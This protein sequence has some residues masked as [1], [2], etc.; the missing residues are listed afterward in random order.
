M[1]FTLRV[2]SSWWTMRS[3]FA[4]MWGLAGIGHAAPLARYNLGGKAPAVVADTVV[5]VYGLGGRSVGFDSL[6]T[7]SRLSAAWKLNALGHWVKVLAGEPRTGHHVWKG[8]K[9]V[10]AGISICSEVRTNLVRYS[11]ALNVSAHWQHYLGISVEPAGELSGIPAFRL[12]DANTDGFS[13]INQT[14]VTHADGVHVFKMLVAKDQN[15]TSR[16]SMRLVYSV[17][18]VGIFSGM[19]VDVAAGSPIY[20]WND[21]VLERKVEDR[22]D[23]WFVWFAVDLTGA[24][25]V[26]VQLFPAHYNE[27]GGSGPAR[28][29]SHVCTAVHFHPGRYPQDYIKTEAAP[30]SVA[31]E[32]LQIDPVKLAKAVGEFGPELVPNSDF[33]DGLT[34]W[35]AASGANLSIT[36]EGG[37]SVE[38]DP[39]DSISLASQQFPTEVDALYLVE[40]D[41]ASATDR[42]FS[43]VS[44]SQS[45]VRNLLPFGINDEVGKLSGFFIGTG[46]DVHLQLGSFDNGATT[47]YRGVTIRKVTMPEVLTF[48][49]KGFMTYED[50]NRW[51]EIVPFRLRK[52]EP[53]IEHIAM[54]LATLDARTGQMYFS[55]MSNSIQNAGVSTAADDKSPGVAVPFSYAWTIGDGISAAA[56]DGVLTTGSAPT[57]LANILGAI[58]DFTYRGDFCLT[59]FAIY[60]G[61]PGSAAMQ[62]VTA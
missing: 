55:H 40:I 26:T 17:D 1:A 42:R 2:P 24:G 58:A 44:T 37:L 57:P 60:V 10:P 46:S 27:N 7:F 3:P 47:V 36:P 45:G 34:G 25:S 38:N 54:E 28:V 4:G 59:E 53:T 23:H 6:F 9:L 50:A 52:T 49:I 20:N 41:I 61:N 48:V 51:S 30:V 14:G 32:S 5:G 43:G 19:S 8:G 18:G 56:S 39:S 16:F 11:E 31:S 15:P 22:G 29:G 35:V 12:T 21:N 13:Q 33:S 62:E